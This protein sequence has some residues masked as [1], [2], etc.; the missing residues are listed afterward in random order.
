VA[1]CLGIIG[2]YQSKDKLLNYI[3]KQKNI[4]SLKIIAVFGE[5]LIQSIHADIVKILTESTGGDGKIKLLLAA[6]DSAYLQEL[7]IIESIPGTISKTT[8]VV[9]EKLKAYDKKAEETKGNSN[10]I[11]KIKVK[12]CD[13]QIRAALVIVNDE[14]AWYTPYLPPLPTESSISMELGKKGG[15]PYIKHCIEHFDKIWNSIEKETIIN[16]DTSNE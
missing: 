14:W 10:K 5:S 6:P 13:T 11:S 9:R 3:R 16:G 1:R 7:G 4:S 12:Y 2:V 8:A 15:K